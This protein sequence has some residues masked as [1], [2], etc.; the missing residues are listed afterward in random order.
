M[1]SEPQTDNRPIIAIVGP[2]ATGKTAVAIGVG[3]ALGAEIISADSQAVYRGM[4]IGTAKPTLQER[5]AVPFHLVDVADPDEAFNVSRFKRLAI[6]ALASIRSRGLLPIVAGGT[7]LYVRALLEDFGLTE[8]P[9]DPCVRE[10]LNA[11]AEKL[12]AGALHIRLSSVDA[13]SANRIH[14]NDRVRIV[15][16]L[17]VYERTGVPISVQQARD[18]ELRHPRPARKFGLTVARDQLYAR[19]ESR[20][21]AMLAAGLVEEVRG[22]HAKSDMP[23]PASLQS[24]GYKEIIAC[25]MGEC[26]LVEAIK[27]NTKRFAK[28]QLTWF[29]ADPEIT[30]IDTADLSQDEVVSRIV[31][32]L[33]A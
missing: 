15:R 29:R 26:D 33:R 32:E 5:Q 23:L 9:S 4:D 11:E 28:R 2:T 18:A 22:L 30:W 25:L 20:V 1:A 6:E 17:E 24:L 21:D 10:K 27:Q 3:Q 19:I 31:T 8:T 13:V 14:P 16:A 7:G 12:G